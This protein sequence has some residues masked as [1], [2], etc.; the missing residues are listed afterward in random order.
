MGFQLPG[1]RL[2]DS[3]RQACSNIPGATVTPHFGRLVGLLVWIGGVGST[4]VGSWVASR[5]RVYDD[6]RK[7]HH[8]EIKQNVLMPLHDGLAGD[9]ARLVTHESPA[10][11]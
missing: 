4:V 1:S 5:I 6:N 11:E 3:Q 9:Y 8:D 2:A 7:A 10:V